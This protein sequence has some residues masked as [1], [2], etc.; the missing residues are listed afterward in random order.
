MPDNL[1]G[2]CLCRAV[3]YTIAGKIKT[4]A[5]CHCNTCKKGIG[6]AFETLAFTDESNFAITEGKDLLTSYQISDRA[7]KHFCL[8]CGTPIYNVHKSFPGNCLVQVGSLDDP[9]LVAPVVNVFCESMLPWV[10][11][12]AEMKCFDQEPTK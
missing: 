9:A 7:T 12:I 6:A 8:V 5:N 2:S 1:S 3:K 10:K 11:H 4:V